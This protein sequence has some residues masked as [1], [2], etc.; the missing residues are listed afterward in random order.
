MFLFLH[1]F[2]TTKVPNPTCEMPRNCA[3]TAAWPW[4]EAASKASSRITP[5][6][7]AW[8]RKM[9]RMRMLW[10]RMRIRIRMRMIMLR[11]G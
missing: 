4:L 10:M 7:R 11:N 2:K 5:P 3:S 1:L 8:A 9:A 6:S